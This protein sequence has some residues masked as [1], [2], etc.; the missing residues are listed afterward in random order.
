MIN[1]KRSLV[2]A[3]PACATT[4]SFSGG[5]PNDRVFGKAHVGV[6]IALDRQE[7]N[8]S[9]TKSESIVL[10]KRP[11]KQNQ[12]TFLVSSLQYH[13]LTLTVYHHNIPPNVSNF[14]PGSLFIQFSR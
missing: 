14:L 1:Q 7:K 13:I 8:V 2:V 6:V 4:G 3:E 9:F 5:F 11:K 12:F 10:F